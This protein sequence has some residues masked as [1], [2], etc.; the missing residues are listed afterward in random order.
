MSPT[1]SSLVGALA[2]TFAVASMPGAPPPFPL[3]GHGAPDA[4]VLAANADNPYGNV[5]KRNDKGN[6]T[7]DG[8]VDTLNSGQLNRNYTGP[9]TDRNVTSTPVPPAAPSPATSR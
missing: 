9:Y 5:D 1:R 2:A 6:D 4:I 7:G 3:P 8:K